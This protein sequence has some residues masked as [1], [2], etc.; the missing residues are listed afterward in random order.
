MDLVKLQKENK[1]NIF[2]KNIDVLI[3]G[4]P[5]QDFSVSGK[6]MGFESTTGHN[7]KKTKGAQKLEPE[8]K[9]ALDIAAKG[10]KFENTIEIIGGL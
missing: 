6:R 4:F 10:T 8:V 7:G 1:I 2:P 9:L 5:C 3:G